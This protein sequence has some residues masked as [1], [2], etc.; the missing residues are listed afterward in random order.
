M[1]ALALGRRGD[2]FPAVKSRAF[3]L[4]VIAAA[5]GLAAVLWWRSQTTAP[6]PVGHP[7]GA[8]TAAPKPPITK[9]KPEVPIE[10][11]KTIDFSSGVPIVKDTA[12]EK[13]AIDRAVKAMED[14][15]KDVT[16]GPPPATKDVGFGPPPAATTKTA[17]EPAKK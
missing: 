11:G 15:A 1:I 17:A 12:T 6:S 3:W 10:D 14:A 4:F 16:F 2:K 7:P 5:L 9:A 13:A 8:Q